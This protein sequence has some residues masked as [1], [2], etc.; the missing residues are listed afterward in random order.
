MDGSRKEHKNKSS[1]FYNQEWFLLFMLEAFLFWLE[2]GELIADFMCKRKYFEIHILEQAILAK[3][4]S[5]F[6]RLYASAWLVS[7][8]K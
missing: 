3:S 7:L 5:P 1:T 6:E 2:S 8:L 4:W